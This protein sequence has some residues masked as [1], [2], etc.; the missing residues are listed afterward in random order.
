WL[1]YLRT[2]E[3]LL[4]RH[5]ADSSLLVTAARG[6]A[7]SKT[8]LDLLLGAMKP[9]TS[10]P[11]HLDL[12]YECRTLHESLVA[13]SKLPM[14]PVS[15]SSTGSS[16]RTSWTLRKLIRSIQS[17]SSDDEQEVTLGGPG[18]PRSCIDAAN[19][20]S[21][22]VASSV[23]KRWSTIHTGSK[24]A[25]AF[26]SLGQQEEEYPD[27]LEP[28]DSR[29]TVQ[30]LSGDDN[31]SSD[32]SDMPDLSYNGSNQGS[33]GS[34]AGS[35]S[36]ANSRCGGGKFKRLQQ[37]WEM[38]SGTPLGTPASSPIKARSRIP[39][40]V[41]SPTPP[42]KPSGLPLPK[43][44]ARKPPL[45]S[46]TGKTPA[47]GPLGSRKP[48]SELITLPSKMSLPSG[49][50]GVR[51]SRVDSVNP[52][53]LATRPSSLPYKKTTVGGLERRA[54]SSSV[55]ARTTAPTSGTPVKYVKTLSHRL[56]SDNGHL[57]YNSGERLK[58]VLEVDDTWLLCC[59]G[60]QKGL[61]PRSAVI[62]Y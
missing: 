29:P 34:T 35:G 36:T 45:P 37:R 59:R 13:L 18:R 22:D 24:L 20:L 23:K 62:L 47:G 56:P 25:L 17:Q 46:P 30:R 9:L 38:L 26:Q 14:S 19:C 61:V 6:N 2:R 12:L 4:R 39:R 42:P 16:L 44:V 41:S 7:T 52:K 49:P 11:F 27:S 1:A 28:I 58:V 57:S 21:S 15:T 48:S 51:Q 31:T 8:L 54:V 5:Y 10:L 33:I 43:P 32:L 60:R 53:P 55:S 40:P 50:T 3:S